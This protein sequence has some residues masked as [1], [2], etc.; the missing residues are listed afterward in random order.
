LLK[1]DVVYVLLKNRC[2]TSYGNVNYTDIAI[3]RLD[4][5]FI[6]IDLIHSKPIKHYNIWQV[7]CWQVCCT[8]DNIMF[9]A[10]HWYNTRETSYKGA[11]IWVVE[12]F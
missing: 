9:T 4:S 6:L 2:H 1:Q 10:V 11:L 5:E 12:A 8:K 7:L 3:G